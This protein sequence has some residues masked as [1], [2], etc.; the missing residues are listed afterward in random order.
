M[1]DF[2]VGLLFIIGVVA[3]VRTI[4]FAESK[5]SAAPAASTEIDASLPIVNQLEQIFSISGIKGTDLKIVPAQGG[6][7]VQFTHDFTFWDETDF[8]NRALGSYVAFCKTAYE[9][10]SATGITFWIYGKMTDQR[11]NENTYNFFSMSMPKETFLSYQ[12]DNIAG[13]NGIYEQIKS[14]CTVLD[15]Y[16]GIR[17]KM[18]TDKIHVTPP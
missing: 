1:R 6:Y 13:V 12:W 2:F 14:D 7:D 11:G 17:A 9:K 4:F 16:A 5:E 3:I 15:I 10:T 8:V 18:E